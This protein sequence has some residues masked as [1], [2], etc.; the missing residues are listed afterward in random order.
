DADGDGHIDLLVAGWDQQVYA[1]HFPGLYVRHRVPWGTLKGNLLRNGV[2]DYRLPTDV[3]G[4]STATAPPLRTALQPN[5]PNP[6]NPTTLIR[7]D[8]G[9]TAAQ[10]VGLHLFDVRGARVRTLLARRLVPG[11]YDVTWDGRNEAGR[12]VA[13]GV[14]FYRLTAPDVSL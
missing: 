7:F 2:I 12:P 9:G 13:S 10:S 5:V 6:F 1:W 11:H 3:G 14:Y 8:S 4:D